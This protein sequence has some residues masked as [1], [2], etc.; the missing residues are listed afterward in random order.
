MLRIAF[1]R[2]TQSACSIAS[3]CLSGCTLCHTC[4]ACALMLAAPAIDAALNEM[5]QE[6]E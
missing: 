6:D 1:L 5:L 4:H 3:L 2:H